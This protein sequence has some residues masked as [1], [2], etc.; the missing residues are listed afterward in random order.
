MT[1]SNSGWLFLFFLILLMRPYDD[2]LAQDTQ[3]LGF[4]AGEM[5]YEDDALNFG[6]GEQDLFITSKLNDNFSFLGETVF[7]FSPNSP[8]DFNVSVER[9]IVSYNY[10]GNHNILFGKHHTPI[11]Y[12]ND[13]YHHGRVFFPTIGRPL[14]FS[15]N[16]IPIHTTGIAFQGLNLGDLRF[17]YNLMIGNGLGATDV[18]ENNKA[19]SITASL[20]IQPWNGWHFGAAL[21]R[22]VISAGSIVHGDLISNRTTQMLYNGTVAYFGKKFELLAESTIA[23]N[24]VDGSGSSTSYASYA[25]AGLRVDDKVVPYV[26]FDNLQYDSQDQFFNNEDTNSYIAGFRYEV[27]YLIVLK[28]EYQYIDRD[29]SG[30]TGLLNT[31][32]AI[33][34]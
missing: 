15:A 31:Q 25:Y 28:M 20:N 16:I 26:R 22:D 6:I 14:L 1:I 19:K 9:I 33:G 11:N 3:I 4:V 8:T 5:Y 12:W 23:N 29:I 10:K 27:S 2:L 32:V 17:G 21:Y 18:A 34:F 13:S 24:D 7:K 30:S